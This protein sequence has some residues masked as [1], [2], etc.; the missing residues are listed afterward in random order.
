[1]SSASLKGSMEPL[2]QGRCSGF[3]GGFK[4]V[5]ISS[6]GF[7]GEGSAEPQDLP[8]A[9]RKEMTLSSLQGALPSC[10]AYP[11]VDCPHK[12]EV[13]V[14]QELPVYGGPQAVSVSGSSLAVLCQVLAR[15]TRA[16]SGLA[17]QE[18]HTCVSVGRPCR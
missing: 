11:F 13:P 6:G 2:A 16:P 8:H 4:A 5:K 10:S 15:C 12:A 9:E 14:G 7:A 1:M 3:G 17:P 18:W